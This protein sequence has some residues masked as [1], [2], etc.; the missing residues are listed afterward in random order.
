MQTNI[1]ESGE[2]LK[3]NTTWHAE[4]SPWKAGN[5]LKMINKNHLKLNSV[6][7]IGCGAGEILNQ[8]HKKLDP[9]IQY[10][11]YD[12]APQAIEIAQSRENNHVQFKLKDLFDEDPSVQFDLVMA[13]DVFEHVE[14]YFGFLKKLK[15]RGEY[16]IFHIPLDININAIIQD[17]F[18][19]GRKTVGH[20]H[21]FTKETALASLEDTG[22]N[23][24]DY[25][26]TADS[27]DLPRKTIKSAIAKIPRQMLFK[28]NPH[29]TVKL[30][31]GFSLMVLAR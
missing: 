1:Y 12:I 3:H 24:L 28:M 18:M 29:F 17:K 8:L 7:E 5:I 16:K 26:Y 11:G 4:D 25:F 20:I 6:C 22:Y 21:Y 2:Y 23:V 31:G 19:Y 30:F 14:D 27:I 10:F 13:I 15:N 9:N